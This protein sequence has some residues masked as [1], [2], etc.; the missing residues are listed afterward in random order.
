MSRTFL[1]GGNFGKAP[2][3]GDGKEG[4]SSSR[5]G[6][7]HVSN[8]GSNRMGVAKLM[9][10]EKMGFLDKGK[11]KSK[12][13]EKREQYLAMMRAKSDRN[14]QMGVD[15]PE[16]RIEGRYKK[17]DVEKLSA[18]AKFVLDRFLEKRRKERDKQ[19][20]KVNVIPVTLRN[21]RVDGNGNIYTPGGRKAGFINLKNGDI[22]NNAGGRMGKYNPKHPMF[23]MTD[24]ERVLDNFRGIAGQGYG[25]GGG[26]I[27]GY[28][29]NNDPWPTGTGTGY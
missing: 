11:Q 19:A 10:M 13:K 6:V 2:S 18:S 21:G 23:A 9:M 26:G 20:A 28:G 3:S 7:G 24:I 4:G 25:G 12:S 16:E 5:G 14:K 27:G 8:V 22:C 15:D 17:E 1:G 29:G